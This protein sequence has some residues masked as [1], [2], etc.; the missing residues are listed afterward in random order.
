RLPD[1]MIPSSFIFL[2]ALPL[3]TNGKVDRR[4]LPSP[5]GARPELKEQFLAP[6]NRTE[7]ILTQA[8]S[9]VLGI[10]KVGVNDN[11][12]ELG[13]DSIQSI[14]ILSRAQQHG[15]KLSLQQL[16]QNP[17]IAGL[18]ALVSGAPVSLPAGSEQSD[19]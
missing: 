6:R 11:F 4:A 14:R 9:E 8:W 18:A 2:E 19:F 12:F 13:G 16:F 1:Y 15:L 10:A 5:D 3:T 17:T 7:E